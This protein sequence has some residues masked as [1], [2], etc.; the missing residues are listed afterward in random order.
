MVEGADER[1]RRLEGRIDDC[2]RHMAVVRYDAD[3][4]SGPQ[5]TSLALLDGRRSGVVVSSIMQRQ[6][7]RV[8]VKPLREGESDLEL[9]PEERAAVDTALAPQPV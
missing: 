2:M 1:V 6:Q 7:A 9:S 5:S 3:G 4:V 8:Y